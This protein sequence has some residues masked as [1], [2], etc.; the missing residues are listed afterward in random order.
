[1]VLQGVIYTHT[2]T[3]FFRGYNTKHLQ[4][5]GSY[6]M[7]CGAGLTCSGGGVGGGVVW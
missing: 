1:M 5:N 3:W 7:Y 6:N 4:L 2:W